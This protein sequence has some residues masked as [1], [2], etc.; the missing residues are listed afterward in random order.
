MR[1]FS[2]VPKEQTA[3]GEPDEMEADFTKGEI[4]AA[5]HGTCPYADQCAIGEQSCS[6][7]EPEMKEIRQGH[8]VACFKV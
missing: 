7:A 4:I 8:Q 5:S 6:E 2:S 1:L 3:T